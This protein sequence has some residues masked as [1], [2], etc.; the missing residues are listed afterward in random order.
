MQH[1]QHKKEK[2]GSS[3][4]FC[5]C[6]DSELYSK[7]TANAPIVLAPSFW[8]ISTPIIRSGF[9]KWPV[10]IQTTVQDSHLWAYTSYTYSLILNTT[11]CFYHFISVE[12]PNLLYIHIYMKRNT[13][14][15]A[16]IG[17]F[18]H[19][20]CANSAVSAVADRFL[21]LWLRSSL[22]KTDWSLMYLQ[23]LTAPLAAAAH[24]HA[25][26]FGQ[27]STNTEEVQRRTTNR[28]KNVRHVTADV[29]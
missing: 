2:T 3:V 28:C 24:R 25:V 1:E 26:T 6:E 19:S 22:I 13:S 29:F 14:D 23:I 7:L 12:G 15:F 16:R 27:L 18:Y 5:T 10:L 20:T 17:K 4:C 8:R 11:L 9:H 21:H